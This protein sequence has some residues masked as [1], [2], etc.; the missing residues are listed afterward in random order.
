MSGISGIFNLDGSPVDRDLLRRMTERIRHR[1]PDRTGYWTSGP[2]GFGHQMFCTTPESLRE[3]Q[4]LAN[5]SGT[6]CL[7]F[8]GRV[9]NREELRTAL[10]STDFHPR[11]DTDAELVLRAYE[12]WGED[13]P[14]KILG[15][16]AYAIWDGGTRR[17]FCAR[18]ILGLKPFYYYTNGRIFLFGSEL[19][20]L[21]EFKEL[22]TKPNEGMIAEHLADEVTNREETL[23][24]G[25][26]RV[27]PAHA[28]VVEAGRSPRKTR[29][30][31]I[32]YSRKIRYGT[33]QEYA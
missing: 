3:Q 25:I 28:L 13:S 30:W 17:L 7:T 26:L 11:D 21:F 32:D 10:R 31:D 9:D 14:C 22:S 12:C 33:A 27:P 6:L 24:E 15:D 1:G 20:Q 23:W 4:P 18:D 2:V 8:D 19:Q 5:D 29:Y 16:F